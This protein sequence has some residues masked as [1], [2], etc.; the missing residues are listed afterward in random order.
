MLTNL[1]DQ[2]A[3]KNIKG[4]ILRPEKNLTFGLVIQK[5]GGHQEGT[6]ETSQGK[7][8]PILGSVLSPQCTLQM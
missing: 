5:S 4:Q 6:G 2:E 1:T 7:I 8:R 3:A